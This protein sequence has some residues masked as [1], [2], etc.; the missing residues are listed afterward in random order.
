VLA[1]DRFELSYTRHEL[2]V[3]GTA[4]DG[5][6]VTQDII[7]AKVKLQLREVM[8]SRTPLSSEYRDGL[9]NRWYLISVYPFRDGVS[10][11]TRDISGKKSEE[12]ERERMVIELQQALAQVRTL[13]GLIPIC[14]WCKNVR[15]D[16]GYWEK[17]E[18]Y[19]HHRSDANFTHSI[20]P[21]CAEKMKA[22]IADAG[23][24]SSP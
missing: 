10:V 17:V 3:T 15:D 24:Q 11:L 19:V 18:D 21:K 4:L 9:T 8:A 20:C 2:D 12:V 23:V 1:L 13:R 14:A 16:K 6:G 22:E 7:G 5:L